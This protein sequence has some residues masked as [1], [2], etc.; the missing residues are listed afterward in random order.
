MKVPVRAGH[1]V[2]LSADQMAHLKALPW[3]VRSVHLSVGQMDHRWVDQ[4]AL[5][6]VDPMV[7]VRAVRSVLLSVD[8]MAHVKVLVSVGQLVH[9]LVGQMDRRRA[10]QKALL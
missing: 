10:G 3:V 1:L 4:K 5:P 6:S 8:Q 7:P 2:P 9:L